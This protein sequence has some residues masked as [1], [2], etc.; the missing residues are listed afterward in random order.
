MADASTDLLRTSGEWLPWLVTNVASPAGLYLIV[1]LERFSTA[2]QGALMIREGPR[3]PAVGCETGDWAH[4]DVYLT[5][6]LDYRALLF[7]GSRW[8]GQ[9]LAW[10]AT[11]AAT[12]VV[13]GADVPGVAA[14][15]RYPGDDVPVVA[16]HAEILVPELLA[17]TWWRQSAS[18]PA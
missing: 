7:A 1:P 11:R 2:E 10:L 6:T 17:A 18:E 5:K 13:V 12:V 4:V 8:D 9:A 16:R 15:L 3:R 14:V